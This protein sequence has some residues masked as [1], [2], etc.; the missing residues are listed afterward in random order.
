M[1]TLCFFFFFQVQLNAVNE[2][3]SKT[4]NPGKPYIEIHPP[5]ASKENGTTSKLLGN[6]IASRPLPTVCC[7]NVFYT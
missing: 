7:R 2:A 1:L 4:D 3:L 5:G 6:D